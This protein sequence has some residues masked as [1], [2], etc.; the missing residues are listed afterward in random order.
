MHVRVKAL[1]TPA[2]P[3]ATWPGR[4]GIEYERFPLRTRNGAHEAVHIEE[5]EH[6]LARDPSLVADAGVSFEPG[7]QLEISPPP[8]ASPSILLH[9]VKSLLERD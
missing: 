6:L 2:E 7:G 1:F 5:V 8:A 9:S 4:V 3:P